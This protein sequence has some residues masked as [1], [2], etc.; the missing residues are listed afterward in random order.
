LLFNVK[1]MYDRAAAGVDTPIVSVSNLTDF[2]IVHR[3]EIETVKLCPAEGIQPLIK[4]L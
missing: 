3:L 2:Y 1:V 4:M